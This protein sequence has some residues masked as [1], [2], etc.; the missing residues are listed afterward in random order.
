MKILVSWIGQTDLRASRNVENAGIGP[1]AQAVTKLTFD[2]V[3]LIS[4][5][6]EQENSSYINWLKSLTSVAIE[7]QYQYLSSPI[8]YEEIY[9]ADIKV[10]NQIL[11]VNGKDVE[12]T[13]HISPGTPAMQTIW[14]ILAKTRFN[15]HLIETSK[16]QGLRTPYIPFEIAAE[17]VP[18][19]RITN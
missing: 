12:L 17:F 14:I 10:V 19:L 5:Y 3:V 8:N 18:K 1:I 2:K 13:F 4:N 11:E 6:S 16:E 15:A 9:Y 7:H